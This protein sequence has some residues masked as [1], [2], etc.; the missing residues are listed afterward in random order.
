MPT[1]EEVPSEVKGEIE[2]LKNALDTLQQN[3]TELCMEI[4]R[5][6]GLLHEKT[7]TERAA[8]E[9]AKESAK[10]AAEQL[11]TIERLQRQISVVRFK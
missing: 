5:L 3:H 11:G 8:A 1:K 9:R 2:G 6:K 10:Q 4:K 7:S